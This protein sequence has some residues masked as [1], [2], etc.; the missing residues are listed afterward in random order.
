MW[1]TVG[2]GLLLVWLAFLL[3]G[4]PLG[5]AAH[6]L[7]LLAMAALTIHGLRAPVRPAAGR[8]SHA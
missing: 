5:L 3:S 4:L 8:S 6:G 7:L 1:W 2:V